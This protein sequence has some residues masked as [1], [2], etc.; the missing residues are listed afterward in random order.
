MAQQR[1]A[2]APVL[3]RVEKKRESSASKLVAYDLETTRIGKGTPRPLYI[4]AYG[5]S[6]DFVLSK[7]VESIEHLREIVI[8]HFLVTKLKGTR[9][10]SW[11][12]NHFD[13]YLIAA[14]LLTS[15][16]FTI[17][18]YLTRSRNL[19][20][21]RVIPW[22]DEHLDPREQ[23]YWEFVDGIAMTGLTGWSL[24]KFL[25]TFS[26]DHQKK[27]GVIDFEHGEEFDADNPQHVEYAE[28]DSIGLFYGIRKAEEIL[29]TFFN[30][31]L[32]VTMGNACIK[33]FKAHLP[34]EKLIQDPGENVTA[35][36]RDLVMRGGYCHAQRR[37]QGPVWKYDINQAYAAAMREAA[38]PAGFAFRS[39]QPHPHAKVFI[40]RLQA[41]K[42]GNVIPFYCKV[43]QGQRFTAIFAEETIPDT[44]LTSIE[45]AQ[46][47]AEGWAI[48]VL[49]CYCWDD[50]F[51]MADYVNKL[52]HVRMTCE[53]GPNGAIGTM[54]KAVGNHSYGKTCEQL[55]PLEVVMAKEC[56][57]GFAEYIAEDESPF[58]AHLWSR[59]VEVAPRDYHKPQ[60]GAFITAHV[61][62]VVR[63]AALVAPDAWLYADTDCVVFSR[64]VTHQLPIDAK[65]YGAF[66]VEA[67]G[68]PYRIITKKVY[69]EIGLDALGEK[70]VKHAKGLNVKRLTEADFEAWY[71]GKPPTQTQV[72]RQN[73]LKVMRGS[74]MFIERVR[75]GTRI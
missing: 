63:R 25:K 24:E 59:P 7:R 15:D 4:T 23:T 36:L 48:D 18:P 39:K 11:N 28:T 34:E 26:P 58:F 27:T 75:R 13:A 51:T 22:G 17:R 12:G 55:E 69:A 43:R 16:E 37:Y 29:L 44:W 42:R 70:G 32:G 73:F 65:R 54:I 56:P 5:E 66:K 10:V 35:I 31:P 3:R 1:G 74:D 2:R 71:Y 20:G 45:F 62:M 41:T 40:V 60:L 49:D 30:R 8:E 14:A 9:F 64:D 53:G 52:E 38:L 19:R 50:Y 72:Q 21:M 33:I 68:V 47:K 57:P 6:P 61:R 67:A 46:L